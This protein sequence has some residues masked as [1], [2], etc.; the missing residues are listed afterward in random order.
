MEDT[1]DRKE[2]RMRARIE[3]LGSA[4]SPERL[5]LTKSMTVQQR[6]ER[7]FTKEEGTLG[8]ATQDRAPSSATIR[9]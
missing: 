5:R 4:Y 1:I 8:G 7:K 9:K 3:G 2:S 6:P